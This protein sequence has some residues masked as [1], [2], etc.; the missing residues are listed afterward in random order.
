[1]ME[2]TEWFESCINQA[3]RILST[4]DLSTLPSKSIDGE[5]FAEG[6]PAIRAV[7]FVFAPDRKRP[8]YIGRATNLCQRWARHSFAGVYRPEGEHHRLRQALTLKGATLRWLEVP[9]EYLGIAE[10]LLIQHYKPRWN[11]QQDLAHPRPAR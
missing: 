8:I 6:L 10:I 5:N 11:G 7:Y 4:L 1:M 2:M 3:R 9:K